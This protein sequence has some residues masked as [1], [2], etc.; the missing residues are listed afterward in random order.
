MVSTSRTEIACSDTSTVQNGSLTMDAKDT[1]R[2]CSLP[3]ARCSRS[4]T[5]LLTCII[6]DALIARFAHLLSK[7]LALACLSGRH[8]G[9]LTRVIGCMHTFLS[10]MGLLLFV[11]FAWRCGL[12]WA[13]MGCFSGIQRRSSCCFWGVWRIGG[14]CCFSMRSPKVLCLFQS[15]SPLVDRPTCMTL[16]VN[17]YCTMER[18]CAK[19]S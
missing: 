11:V 7:A 9:L 12:V 18:H 3:H 10:R 2:S 4:S 5:Q 6:K 15:S 13:S 14:H 16:Q 8:G 1:R 17:P 19:T